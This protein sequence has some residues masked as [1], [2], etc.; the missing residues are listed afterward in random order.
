MEEEIIAET[1]QGDAGSNEGESA[2]EIANSSP[3]KRGRGR[4]KGSKK[5]KVGVTDVNL[6]D[7]VS[8]ISNGEAKPAP[9]RRGRRPK[10]SQEE[11]TEEQESEDNHTDSPVKIHKRPGRP[12]GSKNKTLKV[13]SSVT[14]GVPAKRGRPRKIVAEVLPNDE[15]DVPK[16]EGD[17]PEG[18][19]NLES[20]T[21]GEENKGSTVTPR[22]RGRKK[23]STNKKPRLDQLSDSAPRRGRGRPR[24]IQV[25]ESGEQLVKRG[26]G[27]PKGSLN[28]KKHGK[29]GRPRKVQ[30]LPPSTS[31]RKRG[32][33]RKSPLKR[34]RPRKYP[35]P[36]PEEINKPR[37][38][39]PLGRPRKYPRVDPPEGAPA[40]LKRSRGRPRKSES[41]KGAHLHKKIPA[42]PSSVSVPNSGTPR[43]RGRPPGSG[44]SE[45]ETPSKRGRPKGAVNKKKVRDETELVD[46]IPNHS[47]ETDDSPA[48]TEEVVEPTV[49]MMP[50]EQ[51]DDVQEMLAEQD[52]GLEVS[53]QE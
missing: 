22:K 15:S 4:S 48:V 52:A 42:P 16:P 11:K 40:A 43:K 44:K 21:E 31:K 32:R 6:M 47:N 29:V 37:V 7:L 34:G 24:K 53:T 30:L 28:K 17:S 36:S 51:E 38:W 46:E 50:I 8:G 39:K 19:E 10:I 5:L 9:K 20:S 26:R 49:E 13:V 2:G 45:G 41:K 12:K 25:P 27:R 35:L 3:P 23:G 33:P 18:S 1:E 14:V